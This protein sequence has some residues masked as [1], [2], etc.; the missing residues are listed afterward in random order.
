MEEEL[1]TSQGPLTWLGRNKVVSALIFVLVVALV[2]G[3]LGIWESPV[4]IMGRAIPAAQ[5]VQTFARG[6]TNFDAQLIWNSLS[7]EL[8]QSLQAQ[9]QEVS[10]IQ[11]QLDALKDRGVRYTAVTYVGG[12]RTTT[13]EAYYLYVFSRKNGET[14]DLESVPY[15]FVVDKSGKIERIE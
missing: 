9:G 12:H 13:G 7:D 5:S 8:V 15:V 6:Q 3:A 14:A 4:K 1:G 11:D 2:T 10:S